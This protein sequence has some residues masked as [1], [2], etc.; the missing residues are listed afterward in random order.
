MTIPRKI[1]TA[2]TLILACAACTPATGAAAAGTLD[3]NQYVYTDSELTI[4]SGGSE[5][6]TFTAGR[7]GQLDRVDLFLRKFG[8]PSAPLTVELRDVSAGAPGGTVMSSGT[9]PASAVPD[10]ADLRAFLPV[11]V[12][13]QVTAGAQYSIVAFSN[14]APG[15]YYWSAATGNPYA[16]GASFHN[17]N[18]Y[19]GAP[20]T[21]A[22]Y[23]GIDFTFRT[24]VASATVTGT[25]GA[26]AHKKCKKKKHH[27]GAAKKKCKKKHRH[28]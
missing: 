15:Y 6:Q 14:T 21:S 10:V 4:S 22:G 3:Q 5:G 13:A 16:G 2:V 17:T 24:Y 25:P 7:T 23:T 8:A 19:G 20:W 27:A 12:N 18:S 28:H 11:S 1:A 26:G 9:I